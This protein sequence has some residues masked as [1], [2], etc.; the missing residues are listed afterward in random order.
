M[1]MSYVEWVCPECKTKNREACNSWMYGS[2]IREC[3]ACRCEYL[4]RRFREVA[5]DG[6]DPRSNNAKIYVKGA[7][8]LLAIAA[9]CAALTYFQYTRGYY[10]IKVVATGSLCL[11]GAIACG[12]L[13]LRIKLGFQNK[14]NDKYMEESRARLR[15]PQYVKKLEAYGYHV[16]ESLKK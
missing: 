12:I 4:E 9:I 8:F 14:A 15:D 16:D 10:S 2:P 7:L 6:F 13:A 3:K 11:L 5:I 1:Q